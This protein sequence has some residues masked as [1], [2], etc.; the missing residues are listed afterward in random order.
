M[1]FDANYGER[2]KY[3]SGVVEDSNGAIVSGTVVTATQL[4]TNQK[5]SSNSD[6]NGRFRF[7]Y[8]PAGNYEI[9]VEKSGF[10]PSIKR[11]AV[12]IGQALDIN[13][14][15]VVG[16]VSA[17]IDVS[18]DSQ[19]IETARTQ[20]TETILPRDVE[21]LPLNGRNYLDL[22]LLV[23]GVSR[24]N[25]GSVQRFAETSAVTGTG[26]SIAGQRNL[27]NG[28]VVD[29][30]SANDDA[31][32]LAGTSYSQDVIREFQVITSGGVAEFGRASGGF[33][34]ILTQSG[35]NTW[36]GRA[37]AFLRNDKLDA[38][39][40]LAPTKDPLEQ[41][42]YGVS[43]GGPINK[44]RTFLFSNFEQTRRDDATVITIS[45]AN[46]ATINSRLDAI[47]FR[48][49]RIETG[50]TPGGN[51]ITNFFTRFDHQLN[52]TN[53]L[54]VTY[55]LYDIKA[56]NSRTVGGINTISRGTGLANRDH[57]IN[58]N[59]VT[60]VSSRSINELR[61]Q[62]RRSNLDA[63]AND[64]TG[65][66]VNITNVA[67]FGIA[68]FSPLERDINLYQLSDSFST[69]F[70][71]HSV[72]VGGEFL[73]NRLNIFFPGAFE[74][75]YNFTSLNNFLTGN[76]SQ[77]QQAFGAPSQFQSNPNFGVFVQD[78]WKA[79]KDL[80]FNLGLRY[81]Q[82]HLPDP[83][84]TD[85]NNLAPRFGVSYA[86][87]DRKTVFRAS[88]GLYY[89]RIPLRATSNALQRDGVKY[90]VALLQPTSPGA[91]VFPNVLSA[92]PSALI[93]KPGVTAID[94]D[95][96]NAYS[97]QAN[98]QVERELPFNSS[99]SLGFIHTRGHNLIVSRNV[100]VPTCSVAINPNQCRPNPNFGNIGRFESSG[101]SYY[102]GLVVSFNKRANRFAGVRVSYTYS[103]AIDN[104]GNAFFFTPQNNFNLRDDRG[105]SDNDQRHRL[106][107]SG[108][109]NTPQADD[110]SLLR[111]VYGGFQLSYIYTYASSLPF[112]ILLGTD[113]NG[114]TNFNDRPIG[115]GRN[116]G[117]GFDF[118]S[119]DLR[120]SRRFKFS[121]RFG[122]EVLAEGFNL[123]NNS[124]FIVP[125]NTFGPGITPIANF[126]TPTSAF[127]PRQIQLGVKFSF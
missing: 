30:S 53:Q 102:D 99:V 118:S 72:K 79:R 89:E 24:T 69:T 92:A 60:T 75:V 115:V 31:A 107:I 14:E 41:Y 17:E 18:A 116:T 112:N 103:K 54:A 20:V 82:Q 95:I 37:Y 77:Y 38:R 63:P 76:Y 36:R 23:P 111:Q 44:D 101:D 90:F 49:P 61:F 73:L 21:N 98:V 3:L 15:L 34:N 125:R 123:F 88:Y 94:P 96:E 48:G 104:A 42:Q 52:S 45:P 39:S 55:A 113:R 9:K 59:N 108:T 12:T 6:E 7:P 121:E 27:N 8:L 33:I 46:V 66:A 119:L 13:F 4:E 43:V 29:G 71:N 57:T 78:E 83:I 11:L 65:P 105:L 56:V 19:I 35:T 50:V 32:D 10:A 62:Y 114:D 117:R 120:I 106:T 127:D 126:G 100:N 67:S 28:F 51:D 70:G 25:T 64:Q 97:Q 40:P 26:I 84:K 122:L 16:E 1:F 93:T 81:D 74:G 87:G 68:T 2:T 80:T 124:N 91:P 58:I 110:S 86:P 47:N 85:N 22:A 5:Q 109:L